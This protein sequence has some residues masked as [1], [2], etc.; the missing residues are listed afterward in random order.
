M[1]IILS[2]VIFL[3]LLVAMAY[4]GVITGLLLGFGLAVFALASLAL[5]IRRAN[6]AS[7]EDR[8]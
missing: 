7:R 5:F 8:S 4:L 2:L 6:R 3:S 1:F